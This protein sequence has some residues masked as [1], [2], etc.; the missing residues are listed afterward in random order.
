MLTFIEN[1]SQV[2]FVRCWDSDG[3]TALTPV[4]GYFSMIRVNDGETIVSPDSNL[5]ISGQD[6]YYFMSGW[7]NATRGFMRYSFKMYFT[8]NTIQ[9]M[10]DYAEVV[11]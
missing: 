3:T 2:F 5:T 7:Q 11:S 8:G 6:V 9:T 1:D 10:H 4:S